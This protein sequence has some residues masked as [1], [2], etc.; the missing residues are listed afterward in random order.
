MFE[1]VKCPVK[2]NKKGK[3]TKGN[4]RVGTKEFRAP[5]AI[6]KVVYLTQ[7]KYLQSFLDGSEDKVEIK[8]V[9]RTTGSEIAEEKSYC[10]K[11]IPKHINPIVKEDIIR[12]ITVA[13]KRIVL[14]SPQRDRGRSYGKTR[15]HN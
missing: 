6:R 14:R 15:R 13:T 11:H 12:K 8:T 7:V 5:S 10:K 4:T 1:C 9:K 2:Y 3:P